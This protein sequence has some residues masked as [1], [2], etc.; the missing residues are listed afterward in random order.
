MP[1]KQNG[2]MQNRNKHTGRQTHKSI[3][4]HYTDIHTMKNDD[5][6]L[7]YNIDAWINQQSQVLP[8]MMAVNQSQ[9][10]MH[11]PP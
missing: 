3:E 8:E 2:E 7:G 11:L 4:I 6:E 9:R 10:F 5:N 1:Y